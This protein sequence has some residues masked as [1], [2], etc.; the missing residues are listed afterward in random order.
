MRFI[1]FNF[2]RRTL[3]GFVISREV[4]WDTSIVQTGILWHAVG[5]MDSRRKVEIELCTFVPAPFRTL[6]VI[7]LTLLAMQISIFPCGILAFE[8]YR[9]GDNVLQS[10][11]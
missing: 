3:V 9:Q 1:R 11:L 4:W 10:S 8:A 6:G 5:A 7:K 2:P